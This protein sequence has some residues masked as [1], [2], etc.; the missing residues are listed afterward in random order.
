MKQSYVVSHVTQEERCMAV[1]IENPILVIGDED[2]RGNILKSVEGFSFDR[3]T[4][5]ELS[6]MKESRCLPMHSCCDLDM[7]HVVYCMYNTGHIS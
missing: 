3:Y 7:P 5:E 6:D 2:D 4:W 1:V